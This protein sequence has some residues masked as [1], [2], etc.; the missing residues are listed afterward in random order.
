MKLP[1]CRV[2]IDEIITDEIKNAGYKTSYQVYYYDEI[3]EEWNMNYPFLNKIAKSKRAVA[4]N[5]SFE[6]L[7]DAINHCYNLNC[8]IEKII[9]LD[10]F[11]NQEQLNQHIKKLSESVVK[12]RK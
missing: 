7:R 6:H 1:I 5:N 8:Q 9:F 11:K 3:L 2:Q 4:D 10:E 12:H